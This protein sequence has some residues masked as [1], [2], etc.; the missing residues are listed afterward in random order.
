MIVAPQ[1]VGQWTVTA[2]GPEGADA[3]LGFSV[4][5]P[6]AETQFVPAGGTRPRR[7]LRQGRTTHLADDPE[8][9]K[10][11][12]TGRRIGH[13][14][15]PWLMVLILILVTAENLLAN[16]FYRERRPAGGRRRRTLGARRPRGS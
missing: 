11:A 15:F 12:I 3:T 8:S 4:N 13:E 7:A 6:L 16:R 10:R 1:P 2:S 14:I 9:L 5:P